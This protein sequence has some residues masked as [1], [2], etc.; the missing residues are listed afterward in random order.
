MDQKKIGSFLKE[1]RNEKGITQE[2]AADEFGVAQRTVSRWETGSNM[3]DLSILIEIAE[4][5]EVDI[6]EI[7]DGERKSENMD[8][9]AKETLIKVAEYADAEKNKLEKKVRKIFIG[10]CLILGSAFIGLFANRLDTILGCVGFTLGI[11]LLVASIM[12]ISKQE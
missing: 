1:L 9:E 2:Q 7:I 4:F 6:K 10:M 3:P 8:K 5:Y 11:I 12:S